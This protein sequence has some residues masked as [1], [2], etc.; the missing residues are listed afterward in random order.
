MALFKQLLQSYS[1]TKKEKE[2][3]ALKILEL[4]RDLA[5]Y[6]TKLHA[7]EDSADKTIQPILKEFEN[8]QNTMDKTEQIHP[9]KK[10]FEHLRYFVSKNLY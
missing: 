10:V 3:K 8:L 2:Q 7:F 9:A 6:K 4:E 1:D 5:I